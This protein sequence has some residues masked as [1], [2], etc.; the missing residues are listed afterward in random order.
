[1]QTWYDPL[2]TGESI[3]KEEKKIRRRINRGKPQV[4][5]YV[6][7][8]A[9]NGTDLLDLVPVHWLRQKE[10]S[11]R[12]PAIVGLAGTKKEAVDLVI[13]M[14]EDCMRERGDADLRS[15]LE[16]REAHKR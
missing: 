12:L 1:M 6:L 13:R 8:L 14:T 4:G 11:S 3:Q 2:Y 5:Y 9:S 10:C 15:F 7:T 16:E